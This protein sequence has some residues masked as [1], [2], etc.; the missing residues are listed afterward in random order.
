MKEGVE[1]LNA[2]WGDTDETK[3]LMEALQLTLRMDR[4]QVLNGKIPEPQVSSKLLGIAAVSTDQLPLGL[5]NLQEMVE[6]F[7]Y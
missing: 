2:T 7:F 5:R 6:T 4:A 1:L 3:T